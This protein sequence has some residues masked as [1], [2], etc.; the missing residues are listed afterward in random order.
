M[1]IAILLAKI[2]VMIAAIIAGLIALFFL[3]A[4][5]LRCGEGNCDSGVNSFLSFFVIPLV[6][7]VEFLIFYLLFIL[8]SSKKSN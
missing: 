2:L 4:G 6:G 5:V 8:K 1:R 7:G 3:F